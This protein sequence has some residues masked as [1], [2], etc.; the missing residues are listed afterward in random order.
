[1]RVSS[2]PG[3]D[4]YGSEEQD[5]ATPG[6]G[7]GAPVARGRLPSSTVLLVASF[8]AFLAF[9]DATIVNVAFPSIRESFPG[10]SIGGL[11]WVLNAYNIVFAAFLVPC[12]R[13]ADLVGRRR[14]FAW[15]VG[16]F[17]AASLLCA[18][19]PSVGFL[20]AARGVQA[21]GAAMLVPASLALVVR[22]FP[23]ERRTHAVGLWGAAAALASGLGPPIGGVLVD[24]GGWRW[25]FLVNLP[26][27][28]VALV[29]ARTRLVESRAPGRRSLPDVGGAAMFALALA[30][31]TL[32]IVQGNSWG[33][34]SWA[35]LGSF[36][37]A[38]VLLGGFVVRS[39]GHRSP[40]LD[41]MLLRIRPFAVGNLATVLAGMG[42][43]AYLLTN[44]LWLTY[45]W[46]YSIL[47]AGLALVPAALVATV[48]AA[49]LGPV[50][51]RRGYVAFI[52]PGAVIWAAAYVWYATQVGLTPDFVGEWLPG[53][54]LSGL[55]VGA[56]LPL[57]GSAALAAVPG[58]RYATASA[59]V[60]SA[61][62][63]GGV[64][65]VSVLVVIIG[66]PTA[67]N[68]ADQL[69]TGWWMTVGCFLLC[70][71]VSAFLGRIRPAA[72]DADDAGSARVEV[73]LPHSP[74]GS[75][76]A[77][78]SVAG[79]P[80]FRRLPEGVRSALESAAHDRHLEAGSWL[81]REGEAASSLFV[82]RA[83]RLEVV[84]GQEVVRELGPGSVVGELAV[85]AEGRRS[86]SVRARRDSTVS[87]VSRDD[88]LAAMAADP[89]AFA[90]LAAVLAEQLRDARPE[91]RAGGTRPTV[92]AV[93]GLHPGAPVGAVTQA[94]VEGLGAHLRAELLPHPDHDALE[95]AEGELD[96]VVLSAGSDD[97]RWAYCLRQADHVVVVAE[98]GTDP[99]ATRS[100]DRAGVDLVLVGNR[101]PEEVVRGW[102][103][104]LEPWQVTS[105]T[106]A[107]LSAAARPLAARIAGR[108]VGVV[109]AGGGARA[110]ASIGVLQELS[111]AGIVV[112]RVAGCSVGSIIAGLFAVGHDADAV[113]EI[114]YA[115][116]VRRQPFSDYT[117]PT[118][119]LAKGKRT[120]QGLRRH[121]GGRAIEALPVQFRCNSVDLLGR[122]AVAHR[123][124]E[125]SEAVIASVALPVL[126]PPR[127]TGDRLL[128]DGGVLDNLPVS[129]LTERDEG[130][131]LAV[132]IAMGSGGSQAVGAGAYA[133]AGR[134][135]AADDDDRQRR[136]GRSRPRP[137][138][139]GD[140][141]AAAGCRPAR[142]PPAR[143][144]RRG[145]SDGRPRAP[146]SDRGAVPPVGVLRGRIAVSPA[147]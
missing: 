92:V 39:R 106:V 51:Q 71:L 87:E 67:A 108:A 19:A 23:G 124:G 95:R 64:L 20:V 46:H 33:W 88:F 16:L 144:R 131:I 12:G 80:L 118:V 128:I 58:G 21:L 132:N 2:Q 10:T 134:H 24:L 111:A 145:R 42:F 77:D 9:L 13:L 60:S 76:P 55:G 127:P 38:A 50:A 85:L 35:V 86:A 109:L 83:G 98:A 49:V 57:L 25:A 52:V 122:S 5:V 4:E 54:L 107:G 6:V 7:P 138:C 69:R 102:C 91:V 59:V 101:P 15:G 78:A 40:L 142:V 8:G 147:R 135:V 104:L 68:A 120:R 105:A 116:F 100:L 32:G 36:A 47:V 31:L 41:P 61:R 30:L 93:L 17:T 43:Y 22:A 14:A 73:H 3:T 125:L 79:V 27:G 37:A 63:V 29:A 115:E 28:L 97:D 53:Q 137:R 89:S 110:F 66:A 65:G 141:A 103:T 96:R 136:S 140:H 75:L 99:A 82:V 11:S 112:D 26:F 146:R 1:M 126:F 121:L 130:P 34:T 81:L 56:T 70:A 133:S 18:V 74:A 139:H 117:L 84:V 44:I 119:S 72:E 114:C 94:L 123:S 45:V 129:L 48:V 90:A 143:S 113:H 62:Q